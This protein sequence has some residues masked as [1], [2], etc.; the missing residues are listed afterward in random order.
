M[1]QGRGFLS[2]KTTEF[3]GPQPHQN[4]C[5]FVQKIIEI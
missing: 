5:I 4:D 3:N 2:N 1:A